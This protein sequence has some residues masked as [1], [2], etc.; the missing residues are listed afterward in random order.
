LLGE[1]IINSTLY[2]QNGAFFIGISL[3]IFHLSLPIT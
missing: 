2:T 1:L 3:T